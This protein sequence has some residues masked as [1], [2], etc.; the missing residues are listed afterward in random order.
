MTPP[1]FSTL[2]DFLAAHARGEISREAHVVCSTSTG[3]VA[4]EAPIGDRSASEIEASEDERDLTLLFR[5]ETSETFVV[6]FAKALG[7]KGWIS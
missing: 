2:A 5:S 4:I 7:M 1:R 6:D 3:E